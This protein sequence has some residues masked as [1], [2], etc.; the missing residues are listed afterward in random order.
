M[1]SIHCLHCIYCLALALMFVACDPI[2]KRK[3]ELNIPSAG[4]HTQ[5]LNFRVDAISDALRAIDD[6]AVGHGMKQRDVDQP[7]QK[8]LMRRAYLI[9]YT[10]ASSGQKSVSLNVE[11]NTKAGNVIITLVDF[12][13]ITQSNLS[14]EIESDL[15]NA[16]RTKYGDKSINAF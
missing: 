9:Q 7:K 6:I 2:Y 14:R 5:D 12:Y 1:K 11:V 8:E 10:E 15:I 4:G 16:M 3:Y 13:R